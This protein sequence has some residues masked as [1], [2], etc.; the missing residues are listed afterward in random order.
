MKKKGLV[1]L[2]AVL[3][4]VLTGIVADKALAAGKEK[5]QISIA[6][7]RPGDAWY[8]LSHA[9]TTF[10][11]ERSEWLRADVVATA[12][13]TDDT[14]LLMKKSE[15]RATHLNVTMIPGMKVWGE[16]QYIPLKIGSL[17]HLASAWVTLDPNLKDLADLKGKA[18]TL[19]RKV[20]KGY[21]WIFA[22]LLKQGGAWDSIKPMHGGLG[23]GLIALRD[24]AA[25]AGV[26]MFNFV[27]PDGFSLGSK[28]EEL[29]TRGTLYFLQQGNVKANIKAIAKAC[30]SEEFTGLNLPTLAFVVPAK[31][32][33]P[34]QKEDMVVVSCPVFWAAG[35]EMPDDVVYEVT[36]ILYEAGKKGDFTAFHMMGK[37]IT[38]DFLTTSFWETEELCRENYH[39]GAL[40]YYD[41]IGV[42][43]KSFGE[44]YKRYL[45]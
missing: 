45:K 40:K 18:V 16:G 34:I 44:L 1:I 30:G 11:N 41:S 7:G 31:A 35:K 38:P 2:L 17:L 9:L 42:R 39:P 20:P 22:D 21:T 36:R 6:A 26:Q 12:G 33:G 10:I 8:V 4:V 3:V 15:K 5:T 29:Q 19:P 37:G 24:G 23:A 27:Y 14:R 13:V 28:L 43:L 32:L 25:Q